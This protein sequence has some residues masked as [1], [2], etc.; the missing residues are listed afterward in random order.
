MAVAPTLLLV[1]EPF[2]SIDAPAGTR[3][4]DE[5]RERRLRG[6]GGSGLARSRGRPRP[7]YCAVRIDAGNI[8]AFGSRR[9]LS[10]GEV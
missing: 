5:L 4:R 7:R 9:E 3:L 2:T 10:G 8:I 6:A 1:D